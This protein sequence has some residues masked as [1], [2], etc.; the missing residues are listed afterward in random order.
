MG[1]D[2]LSNVQRKVYDAT[3]LMLQNI[4]TALANNAN[5]CYVEQQTKGLADDAGEFFEDADEL[6]KIVAARNLKL[7]MC[8]GALAFTTSFCVALPLV[9]SFVGVS[10]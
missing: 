2:E 1:K 6:G 8:F 10:T 3:G 7:K 9:D 5:I 4:E